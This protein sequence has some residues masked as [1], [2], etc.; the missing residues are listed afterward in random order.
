MATKKLTWYNVDDVNRGDPSKN[1]EHIA[2]I[3]EHDRDCT[4]GCLEARRADDVELGRELLLACGHEVERVAEGHVVEDDVAD[5]CA[6]NQNRSDRLQPVCL[7]LGC[8]RVARQDD[9]GRVVHSAE[10]TC[11][12]HDDVEAKDEDNGSS[13]DLH[14]AIFDRVH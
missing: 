12:R 14:Q 9:L 2:H 8:G 7:P 11:E 3:R 1:G 5:H 6:E 10:V 13:D 4:G